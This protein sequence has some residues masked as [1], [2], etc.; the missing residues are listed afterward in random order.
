MVNTELREILDFLKERV[1][2]KEFNVN[3][4]INV[5]SEILN[6]KKEEYEQFK[7]EIKLKWDE[8]NH[9]NE[10]RI[11][12]KT[13]TTFFYNNF[14][15]LF[16]FFTNKFF[17]FDEKSLELVIKEKISDKILFLEYNYLLTLEEKNHF[18]N[19]SK[20]LKVG[21]FHGFSFTTGFLFFL[22]R[23]LGMIFRKTI[24]EKI[25]ILLDG[26]II[27]EEE[28]NSSLKFMIIIKD[29]KD[30]IFYSYYN[31]ALYYFL[32]HFK[33]IPENFYDKL[34]DGREK[35]YQTALAEYPFAKEKLV[36]LLYYFYK[37]CNLLQS[38]SPLLDFFNF[39]GSRVEDS[40][41]SKV[42]TI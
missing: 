34:L 31:M 5:F 19:T 33:G 15:E 21:I 35:L 4:E 24:Q 41:F 13:F 22:I 16:K 8:F 9:K 23:Q 37:K 14:H 25:F 7:K 28:N 40:I 36:D 1:D 18:D 17:G 30:E 10:K 2:G 3:F 6:K 27:R 12:K 29:S 26:I 11:I 32:R 39:V 20:D 42:E 38:F